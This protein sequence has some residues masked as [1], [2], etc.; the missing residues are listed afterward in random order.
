M[1]SR[2]IKLEQVYMYDNAWF[3]GSTVHS[4]HAGRPVHG[5]EREMHKL[6]LE[7]RHGSAM[8]PR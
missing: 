1:T 3:D 5:H 4:C 6:D 7:G 2:E 8:Y